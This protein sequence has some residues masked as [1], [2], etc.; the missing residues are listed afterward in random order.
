MILLL[1][2]LIMF[3]T[4]DPDF[5]AVRMG[6]K[7]RIFSKIS[8]CTGAVY[9]SGDNRVLFQDGV[10]KIGTLKSDLDCTTLSSVVE[11]EFRTKEMQ[12]PKNDAWISWIDIKNIDIYGNSPESWILVKG[13]DK[14]VEVTD[15]KLVGGTRRHSESKEDCLR[16]DWVKKYYDRDIVVSFQYSYCYYDFVDQAELRYGYGAIIL[17]HPAGKNIEIFFPLVSNNNRNYRE[18]SS[19]SESCR[20]SDSIFSNF[21][22]SNS[23]CY[24]CC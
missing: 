17:I 6:R 23:S 3:A 20:S 24:P 15:I 4:A 7:Y 18:E 1:F 2:V 14:N 16:E 8:E 22:H 5:Y 9:K 11:E 13:F 12:M 19:E 21:R 10:W